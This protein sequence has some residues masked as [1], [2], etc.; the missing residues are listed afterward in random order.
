VKN[1]LQ[2]HRLHGFTIHSQNVFSIAW[3]RSSTPNDIPWFCHGS[4]RESFD[5]AEHEFYEWQG[6][7]PLTHNTSEF[8]SINLAIYDQAK[9]W[10]QERYARL[11]KCCGDERFLIKL[12]DDRFEVY[13]FDEDFHMKRENKAYRTERDRRAAER[14]KKRQQEAEKI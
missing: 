9:Y 10:E 3:K 13:C 2:R 14:S 5:E 8:C 11:W 1:D 12:F 6:E 7:K 4:G